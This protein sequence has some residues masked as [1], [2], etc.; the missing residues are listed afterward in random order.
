MSTTPSI[1]KRPRVPYTVL[2]GA[3]VDRIRKE[4][5][6][7]SL[8]VLNRGSRFDREQSLALLTEARSGDILW[9]E[10]PR[11]SYEIEPLSRRYPDVRFLLLQEEASPGEWVNL[12]IEETRS[13]HV[14]V[15]WS[16]MRLHP[17]TL[18]LLQAQLVEA[19]E[20]GSRVPPGT[21]GGP[22]SS[23]QERPALCLVP[24]LRG[25]GG[26]VLP[27]I[28][29]PALVRGRLSVLPFSPVRAGMSS[30]LPYDYCGVFD[31]G[32]F[33]ACGGFDTWMRNPYWQKL[34]F[35]LRCGLWGERIR[36]H[37]GLEMRYLE[38]PAAEDTSPDSSY[39]LFYLKNVAV[40]FNG[41]LGVLP[42]SRWLTYALRSGSGLVDSLREFREIQDWV[43]EQRYRFQRDLAGLVNRWELPA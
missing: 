7:L 9:V 13:R 37:D 1:F 20:R 41:E 40:R 14:L 31:R 18:R 24:Q 19:S 25:P 43:H 12:G 32:R 29:V 38:E 28:Q 17:E 6:A 11:I 39:K 10:G 27:T 33:H 42:W 36:L 26:E 8:L 34:D 4:Q 21:G 5:G 3:R 35:G 2:G 30:L 15:L 23:P 16:D 22:R